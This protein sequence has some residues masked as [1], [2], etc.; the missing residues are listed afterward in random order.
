MTV[1]HDLPMSG[2]DYVDSNGV[3]HMSSTGGG[4]LVRTEADIANL[5]ASYNPGTIAHT[6]GWQLAWEKAY[7]GSWVN[8][9]GGEDNG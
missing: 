6:A 4:V 8:I 9:V 2:S 3:L 1:L 5:P 7:D